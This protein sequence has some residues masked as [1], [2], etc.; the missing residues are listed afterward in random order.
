MHILIVDDSKFMRRTVIKALDEIGSFSTVEA[1][2]GEE[3]LAKLKEEDK[4]D[5]MISDWN[6]PVMNGLELVTRVRKQSDM[7]IFMITTVSAKEDVK[8]AL[9]AGVS[10]YILK[11][12]ET[13]E[14][15][16]K[17]QL[18]FPELELG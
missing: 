4:V 3:A 9:R 17:L 13:A 16:N 7:T 5:L 1:G 14:L 10:N 15:R 2:N 8:D 11:P 12:L 6:M 18:H